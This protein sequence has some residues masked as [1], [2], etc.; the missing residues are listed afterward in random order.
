MENEA[1]P[2]ERLFGRIR[3]PFEEFLRRTTAGGIVL[4]TTTLIALALASI[5][6]EDVVDPFWH[7][8]FSLVA[9]NFELSMSWHH[10]VN[11]GLMAL[12][13]LLVGLE[14]K[15]EMLVGELSSLKDAA[16]PVVA[17]IGG[18]VVPALLYLVFNAGTPAA[19]GWGIPMAT[20]IAFA[21][22]I[23]VL[24]AWRIPRNLVVFLTALAIADDLG[25]VLVI[26]LFYT[27]DLD[28]GALWAALALL[29]VLVLFNRAG[30]RHPLPYI[31]LGLLLWEAL[32][33]SGIHATLAG[34]LL[35]FTI[36]ARPAY[37]PAIFERR[38]NELQAAF[39]ADRRDSHTSGDPL[40]NSRMAS[41]AEAMEHSAISVQSPLQRM[42]HSLTPWVTFAIIPAFALAN[43]GIDLLSVAWSDTLSS[44]ITLGIVA[45]LVLGK[46]LGIGAFSWIAVRLGLARLPAGVRW[47]DLTG[48]AWLA[49]IGFTMSLFIA[50]LAFRDPALVEQ[51][52]VGILIASAISASIGLV[53]LYVAGSRRTRPL[54]GADE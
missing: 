51:A 38:I 6:G 9:E 18:M 34:V 53:W 13:F 21:V 49:G 48:A 25:A 35:A 27:G 46:F 32:H 40:S 30:I 20:D 10:W 19:H 37:T 44:R 50:Q 22:G 29:T 3:T 14:L 2:L 16:L 23:L 17:A 47:I 45:G 54:T 11:D 36:P 33:V 41:I 5:L 1:Y 12:F 15:R 26:A 52:K 8:K 43:A 24:L 7:R 39:R 42:E 28:Q 4:I 31:L